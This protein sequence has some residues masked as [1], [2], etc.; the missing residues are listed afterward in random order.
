MVGDRW[1]DIDAGAAAG[2][3]TVWIDRG[4][5]ERAPEHAPDAR[6]D[7]LRAA[8]DWI[9]LRG[10]CETECHSDWHSLESA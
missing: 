5:D 7:S 1:R 2:C 3:R 6:V 8:A 4:Y 10:G 9:V